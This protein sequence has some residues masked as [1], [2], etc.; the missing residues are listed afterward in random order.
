MGA[1]RQ[2]KDSVFSLLF[3]DPD[4]L[5]E[6]YS[7]LSGVSLDPAVPIT[8]NTLENVLYM[9]RINDISFAVADKIVIV[10]E[11]QSTINPN[12]PLRILM[13]IAAIYE[14]F[15]V[16]KGSSAVYTR[17]LL[18]LPRP[19]FIVL[20]N[21]KAPLPEKM[22]LKLSDSFAGAG[23]AGRPA[24]LELAVTLYN[25][26]RGYNEGLVRKCRVLE[27]YSIF[28]GKVRE[29]EAAGLS[30]EEAVGEAVEW[31]IGNGILQNF[32]RIHATEVKNM[33][34]AEWKFEDA[35]VVEREEGREEGREKD[36]KLLKIYG[37]NPGQIAAALR[38]PLDK[39]LRYLED[40]AAERA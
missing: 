14:K 25:I 26:N 39:V 12:M 6:L 34:T 36:V 37:M 5:R 10:L 40:D 16:E 17:K 22:V 9:D 29:Y 32:L 7:A 35:L 13:Y 1:N 8:I 19:E 30:L 18:R 23:E 20:Y 2:Y 11:H 31:C 3:S 27:G 38:L 24:D 21:G 15:I 28:V 4:T 33:L